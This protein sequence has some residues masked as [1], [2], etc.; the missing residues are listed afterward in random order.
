MYGSALRRLLEL[1]PNGCS[2]DQ[3][4]WRMKSSGFRIDAS[5]L[6]HAFNELSAN[7]EAIVKADGR[8]HLRRFTNVQGVGTLGEAR[9][10]PSD[11][12][13]LIAVPLTCG[14]R[15]VGDIEDEEVLEV[16]TVPR[17]T[18]DLAGQWKSLMGY[19]AATQR[20]DPRGKI[21]QF[22]E[23][24]GTAFQLFTTVGEWWSGA[25][26][27]INVTSLPEGFREALVRRKENSCAIGYPLA[28]IEGP[29]GH[30]CIPA[31]LI[32]AERHIIEDRL[33]LS[34]AITDPVINPEWLK[35]VARKSRWKEQDLVDALLPEDQPRDLDAVTRRMRNALAKFGGAELAAGKLDETVMLGRDG[36]RNAAALFLAVDRSYTQGTAMD[37]EAMA[38]LPDAERQGTALAA[39][40]AGSP[41][42]VV[43]TE[44]HPLIQLQDLTERQFEAACDMQSVPLSVVQGPPGTGKSDVIVSVIASAVAAGQSV[45]FASK[46]HQALDEVE[47]RLAAF[48]GDVP[49]LVRGRDSDGERNTNFLAELKSLAQTEPVNLSAIP[50][51]IVFQIAAQNE[52]FKRRRKQ[53]IELELQLAAILDLLDRIGKDNVSPALP[54]YLRWF[55]VLIRRFDQSYVVQAATTGDTSTSLRK[56]AD[57]LYRKLS[58][59]DPMPN[60]ADFSPHDE[61]HKAAL[62][63]ALRELFIRRATLDPLSRIQLQATISELEFSDTKPHPRNLMDE[64]ARLLLR[65][66]PVWLISTLSVPSRVPLVP[67]LFDLLVIDE[68]SQCDIASSLP[69]FHRAKRAAVVGDPLQLGFVPGLSVRQ[70]HALMDHAGLPKVG[71]AA[72]AQS[73]RSLFEFAD[74]RPAART[75]FLADQFRSASDIVDYLND[76]FYANRLRARR[77]D[78]QLITVPQYRPGIDWVDVKGKA[79]RIEDANINDE[80]AKEVAKR[81]VSLASDKKFTGSIGALTPFVGQVARIITEVD[82]LKGPNWRKSRAIKIATIDKFQGG[83][84]DVIFFSLVVNAGGPVSAISFLQRERRRFNVAI[85][86][87]KAACI[88]IGDLDAA[89]SSSIP[90]LRRLAWH[91][92]RQQ[93]DIAHEMDSR[94][95]EI[96]SGA[97][98]KRGLD[99]IAQY[100]IGRRRLDFALF[101][102]DVKLD[103]EVDGRAFHTDPDGQRKT[104]DLLRD[105]EM[106]ARGWKVRRFWVSELE[107]DMEKCLDLIESDLTV[108]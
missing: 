22:T 11:V 72:I 96:L 76:G 101:H 7:G 92:T 43:Q 97:L 56:D 33:I 87:A 30:E 59:I 51:A 60:A 95:E 85:S 84:A 39:L 9:G 40:L 67:G 53:R 100:E 29:S 74:T 66:R 102:G 35:Q 19:Y 99:P 86:R 78:D 80:E 25:P 89:K 16:S 70:E 27:S 65:H 31:L 49:V 3:I 77:S 15:P 81:I 79:Q 21:S 108:N 32:A 2:K 45:L 44:S 14:L 1:Y 8:W 64:D 63:E 28:L 50:R 34:V 17:G 91:A 55:S 107:R 48:C 69:L 104:S 47:Q 71:R 18:M 73:K 42:P 20:S 88:I 24:H 46:N 58:T 10:G 54:W 103:V 82:A 94:W 105:K 90:H 13:R 12:K 68:A 36:M 23:R 75:H 41:N 98:K 57:T 93:S 6:L 5:G 26:L 37:L 62:G 106:L 83:E 52:A 61:A 4:L 38:D